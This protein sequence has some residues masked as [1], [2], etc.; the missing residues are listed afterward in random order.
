METFAE[1]A[2]VVGGLRELLWERGEWRSAVVPGKEVEG[3]K[4]SDYFSATERVR[5][6]AVARA[7]ALLRGRKDR[8]PPSHDG[9]PEDGSAD[10]PTEPERRIAARAGVEISG[11]PADRWLAET[12]PWTWRV[13]VLPLVWRPKPNSGCVSRP[14]SRRFACSVATFTTCCWRR[15]PDE[16]ATMGL[17]PGIRTGVKAAVVD[18]TGKLLATATVYPHEPRRDWEGSLRVL[19]ALCEKHGVE[20]ISVGNGTASRE[21]DKLAGELIQRHPHLSLTKVVVSEAGASVYRRRSW[22]P[23]SSRPRRL[24]SRRGVDRAAAAGP[25]GRAGAHRAEGD[26]GWPVPARRQRDATGQGRRRG[27]RRLRQRR[28]RRSEHGVGAAARAHLR[29]QRIARAQHRVVPR[30]AR[31]LPQP[32]AV[33]EGAALGERTFHRPPAFSASPM[34]TTRSTRPPCIRRPIPS[35]IGSSS[36]LAWRCAISSAAPVLRALKPEDFVDAQFGLPTVRT[37][38]RSSIVRAAILVRSSGRR[39]SKTVRRSAIWSRACCSRAW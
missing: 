16:R 11:R 20:L 29:P 37:S 35:S 27:R 39:R 34:A 31:R 23:R 13:K 33:A 28:G 36:A 10:G 18:G 17:D 4:Y 22:R 25:A 26:R 9:L 3:V 2:Q 8:H 21:T 38:S 6:G 7:L 24:A 19:A 30:R 15:R 12:M 32:P 1:D 14:S 5:Y